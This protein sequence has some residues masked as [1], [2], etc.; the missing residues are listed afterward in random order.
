MDKE[1]LGYYWLKQGFSTWFRCLF[2][3]IENTPFIVEPL[4]DGLF[5]YFDKLYNQEV[6][7]LNINVPPRSGKTTLATYL[8]VYALTKNP[9]SNIIYT[10]FSQTLLNDIASRVKD[11]LENPIYKSLYPSSMNYQEEETSPIDDFWLDYLKKESGKNTYSTKR[12]TTSQGGICLFSSIGSQITGYGAGIR[13]GKGFTGA[14]IIDDANKP[15]DIRSQVMREKVVRYFEET[16]L[17]RLNKSDVPIVNIQQRLHLEDLSGVLQER[18]GFETLKRALIDKDGKCQLPSQ[19]TPERIAELKVNNYMFL[20]QY[21]QE[22]IVLGGQVIKR[23]WFKY[24]N[25]TQEYKY[26]RLII[27]ADTAMKVKE[28]NDYSV[29]LVGG[30]TQNNHLHLIEMLRGKWEAPELKRNALALFEKYK[31]NENTGIGCSGIYVEDKASGTGLIQE[32]SRAGAP[33]VG[34]TTDKDKLTRLEGVLTY[35]ASGQVLLPYDDTYG[36]NP[37]LLSECEAFTRDDSHAHDDIVDAL[38]YL[39][40]ESLVR[41]NV[42]LLDYFM[43]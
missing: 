9:K 8:V 11:I 17:S 24:Y 5:E 41:N 40:Q 19:Y 31:Y 16:L 33:I 29:F 15:A 12:I 21:Q 4:H 14:L 30:I 32:L 25:P 23:E 22:P 28:Y 26:Q 2:R 10:S 38:V 37:E 3:L 34:L 7:R 43:D 36:F 6:T 18:Y 35:I 42:S 1:F 27:A 20:S 13:N 39:I